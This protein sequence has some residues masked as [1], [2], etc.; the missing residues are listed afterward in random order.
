MDRNK[1]G[2]MKIQIISGH[3]VPS[4]AERLYSFCWRPLILKQSMIHSLQSH[5]EIC[6]TMRSEAFTAKTTKEKNENQVTGVR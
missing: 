1:S 5:T 4:I 6:Q 3:K 2:P